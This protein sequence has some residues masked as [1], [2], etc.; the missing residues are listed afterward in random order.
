LEETSRMETS[1]VLYAVNIPAILGTL[2]LIALILIVLG[3]K[4]KNNPTRRITLLRTGIVLIGLTILLTG[5]LW[6]A[7]LAMT[8]VPLPVY[9]QDVVLLT[10][11][12]I[13]GGMAIGAALA[14]KGT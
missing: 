3:F 14:M 1:E 10:L 6:Y 11:F 2:L 12:S 5:F 7:N 8:H 4:E 13:G 9:I